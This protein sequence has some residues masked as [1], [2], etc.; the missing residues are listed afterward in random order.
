MWRQSS[1]G[2]CRFF[3]TEM[4][5]RAARPYPVRVVQAAT[6]ITQPRSFLILTPACGSRPNLAQV[7]KGADFHRDAVGFLKSLVSDRRAQI[8]VHLC[9]NKIRKRRGYDYFVAS[10]DATDAP[11]APDGPPSEAGQ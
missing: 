6:D 10:A 7:K 5:F 3:Q 4:F 11:C 1:N 8:L 9:K 2:G